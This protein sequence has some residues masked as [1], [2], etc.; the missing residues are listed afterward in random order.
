MTFACTRMY[1]C[2]ARIYSYVTRISLEFNT[3]VYGSI[4]L[5]SYTTTP[6]LSGDERSKV[7]SK[8]PC[9]Y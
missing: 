3:S 1:S 8:W 5:I 4:Q 2:V 7:N 9:T 6:Y